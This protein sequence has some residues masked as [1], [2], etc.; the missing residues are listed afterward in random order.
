MKLVAWL[1]LIF[2]SFES[3]AQKIKSDSEVHLLKSY[4]EVNLPEGLDK[5]NLQ[6]TIFDQFS[7]TN[8]KINESAIN[9]S[10]LLNRS[11]ILDSKAGRL[12]LDVFV[13]E[14]PYS[15]FYSAKQNEK[16]TIIYMPELRSTYQG[17]SALYLDNKM[18]DYRPIVLST[19]PVRSP[20]FSY[21]TANVTEYNDNDTSTTL[22]RMATSNLEEVTAWVDV[23]VKPAVPAQKQVDMVNAKQVEKIYRIALLKFLD[24][25]DV[26][27]H[28]TSTTLY[29]VKTK[30]GEYV[31]LDSTYKATLACLKQMTA[32]TYESS[33]N[34]L[35]SSIQIWKEEKEKFNSFAPEQAPHAWA[36]CMNIAT[37]ADLLD[38]YKTAASYMQEA[39]KIGSD[40]KSSDRLKYYL[41]PRI[42]KYNLRYDTNGNY[43]A[44]S[45]VY[46][47]QVPPEVEYQKRADELQKQELA[48][49]KAE[50]EK[51]AE[52]YKYTIINQPGQVVTIDGQ[53]FK[54]D[55]SYSPDRK[56]LLESGD[57]GDDMVYF[58]FKNEKGKEKLRIYKGSTL[59]SF[60]VNNEVYESVTIELNEKEKVR[61]QF[62]QHRRFYKVLYQSP[63]IT[64]YS[65][66]NHSVH[67]HAF[68]LAGAEVGYCTGFGEFQTDSKKALAEVFKASPI[69]FKHVSNSTANLFTDQSLTQLCESYTLAL[70]NKQ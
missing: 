19:N 63:A 24:K 31:R 15:F 10:L 55:I 40:R 62:R 8:Q 41:Q 61:N 60:S 39:D 7:L 14:Q 13:E 47:D 44:S 28:Q 27:Y 52:R 49:L 11:F 58:Y 43:Q 64:L 20:L 48:R 65:Y 6:L 70:K 29:K 32:A 23:T 50:K 22:Y 56:T 69:V 30:D 1:V 59:K 34:Q 57:P 38:D 12:R 21:G 37:A 5:L 45:F 36:L 33:L 2:I 4:P 18:I 3:I 16:G 17:K 25:Y 66:N 67:Q 51:D 9:N 53:V 26:K 46:L 54:G 42:N 68:K 35:K